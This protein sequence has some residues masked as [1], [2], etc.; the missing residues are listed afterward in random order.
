MIK[1]RVDST[2]EERKQ[3]ALGID[4]DEVTLIAEAINGIHA[5]VQC[6]MQLTKNNSRLQQTIGNLITVSVTGDIYKMQQHPE[7]IDDGCEVVTRE[8]TEL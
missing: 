6:A 1:M 7:T 3:I 4:G 2:R 8:E 5:L